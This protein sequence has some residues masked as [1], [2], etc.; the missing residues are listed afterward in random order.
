MQKIVLVIPFLFA[1]ICLEAQIHLDSLHTVWQD[2][3]QSDSIR[4]AAYKTYIWN[5]F[6]YNQPDTACILAEELLDFGRDKNYLYAAVLAYNIQGVSWYLRGDYPKALGYYRKSLKIDEQMGNQRGISATLNNIG[7]I[8]VNQGDYPKALDYYTKGLKIDEKVGDQKGIAQSLN[9]IGIIY[10]NLADYPKALDYYSQSLKIKEQIGDQKG[11]AASLNNIG[12]IYQYQR[13]YPKALDCYSQSLKIK[14]E[15]GDQ[16]GIAPSLHNIGIIYNILGDYAM[17]K[18]YFTKSLKIKEQIGDQKGIA[19]S[20]NNIGGV[21][22]IQGD[23]SKALAYCQKAY[24]LALALG[25]LESLKDG[26]SCLYETYKA[27]GNGSKALE[28]YELLHVINDSLHA[29]ETA[30]KLQQIEFQKIM[31]QDSIVKEEEARLLREAHSAEVR[32]KNRTQN[33]YLA[34]GVILIFISLG[35]WRGLHFVRRSRKLITHEK[36]KSDKLLLS[37]LPEE[38]AEELKRTGEAKPR[39]YEHV[40]ILFTDFVDFAR[41][42]EQMGPEE[43]VTEINACYKSFDRIIEK[44]GAEKI[45]T[46]GDTYMAMDGFCR[47]P[48]LAAGNMVRAALEICDFVS[49]RKKQRDAAGKPA[50]AIRAGIH[51]G[52]VVAGIVGEKKFQFDIWGDAVNTASRMEAHS[53]VGKVNISEAVFELLKEEPGFAFESRGKIKVKGKGEM[54]MWFVS[55]KTAQE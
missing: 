29:D 15:I 12:L 11:V 43:L 2:P 50:F 35:L 25:V 1:G 13:D 34:G 54:D 10:N 49:D 24:E 46:I 5:G 41:I 7:L 9:N 44:Q 21:Y 53:D 17:A 37:I 4:A 42:S 26:C 48:N 6:L 55:L 51:T 33:L 47:K 31:F 8:Y 28:Y 23:Y 30:K 18:D 52:D 40:S 32:K 22:R 39:K 16:M 3:S 27:M 36:E 19:N 14:E 38:I 20:L 45:K